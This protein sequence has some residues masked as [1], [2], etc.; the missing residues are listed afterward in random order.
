MAKGKEI[1]K[2]N[3]AEVEN[4]IEQIRGTNLEPSAKE[5]IERL[6]RTILILVELL[7][8]KKTSISRLREMLLESAPRSIKR[9]RPMESKR[10][11][12]TRHRMRKSL[13]L[14]NP[15]QGVIKLRRWNRRAVKIKRRRARRGTDTVRQVTIPE[16]KSS[17]AGM[18]F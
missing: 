6:L 10:R 9:R 8:R 17:N 3:P 13:V 15:R 12:E 4:L 18:R 1:P 14:L 7:Q 16:R 11:K 2:T 5:K